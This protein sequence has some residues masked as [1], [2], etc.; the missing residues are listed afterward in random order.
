MT[1]S[2]DESFYLWT[3]VP[4]VDC[5]ADNGGCHVFATCFQ[6]AVDQLMCSCKPGYHGD[7][8]Y[9]Q[10]IDVCTTNNG[11]CGVNATCL[12]IAPVTL[13]VICFFTYIFTITA[14][15]L[16]RSLAYLYCQ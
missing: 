1:I 3:L 5:K 8:Y 14:E 16:A 10:M 9:C 13:P 12:F 4:S 6:T 2:K 15:I 7:G 11:G